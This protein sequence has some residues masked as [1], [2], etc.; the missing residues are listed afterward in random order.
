MPLLVFPIK[1][2]CASVCSE[3]RILF[4]SHCINPETLLNRQFPTKPLDILI[5]NLGA[6]MKCQLV[7]A[8]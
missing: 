4:I 6:F 2:V 1:I 7:N 3:G 8:V 5:G